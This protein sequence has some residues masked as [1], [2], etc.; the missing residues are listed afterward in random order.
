MDYDRF[1]RIVR[2]A[3]RTGDRD[4]KRAARATL[5][6]LG[7][8]LD[9]DDAIELAAKLPGELSAWLLT[10]RDRGAFVALRELVG[11]DEFFDVVVELPSEYVETLSS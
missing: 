6:T 2:R 1:V 7:E 5:E 4:A 8:R 3:G 10:A 9:E 11:D